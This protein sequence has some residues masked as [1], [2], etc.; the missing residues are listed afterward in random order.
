MVDTIPWMMFFFHHCLLSRTGDDNSSKS[1]FICLAV[2]LP[3]AS[4]SGVIQGIR[5]LP[6]LELYKDSQ[7]EEFKPSLPLA[8]LHLIALSLSFL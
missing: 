3:V 1:G 8:S 4:R 2:S 5:A 6:Q 7:G